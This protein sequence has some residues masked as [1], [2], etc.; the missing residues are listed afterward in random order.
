VVRNRTRRPSPPPVQ[1]APEPWTCTEEGCGLIIAVKPES[2][3]QTMDEIAAHKA[4]HQPPVPTT[5]PPVNEVAGPPPQASGPHPQAT[6]GLE[7]RL[8]QFEQQVTAG[9]KVIQDNMETL[10]RTQNQ[11]GQIISQMQVVPPTPSGGLPGPDGQVPIAGYVMNPGMQVQPPQQEDLIT[12]I[13]GAIASRM[14]AGGGA[15]VGDSGIGGLVKAL[16]GISSIG[17][18]FNGLRNVFLEPFLQGSEY[19]ARTL[20]AANAAGIETTPALDSIIAHD[21]AALETLKPV[22]PP[23]PAPAV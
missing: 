18:A 19:T 1:K 23:T 4:M 17:Q 16:E 5:P 10:S 9:F 21:R 11:L 22:Q 6:P 20:K 8:A 15:S 13:I 2:I 7:E 3:A 14:L 12:K